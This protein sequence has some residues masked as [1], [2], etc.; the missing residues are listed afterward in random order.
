VVGGGRVAERKVATL[1]GADADVVVVAP[2]VTPSLRRR[3]SS[4]RIRWRRAAYRASHLRGA[5]F[6]V[7][8]TSNPSVNREVALAAGRAG[9]FVAVADDARLC[10]LFMPAVLRRGDLLVAVSTGGRSPGLARLLRDELARGLAPGHDALVR[11]VGALRESLRLGLR[12]ARE[13]ARLIGRILRAPV[14]SRAHS[15]S[16]R[17]GSAG[18]RRHGRSS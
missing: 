7:A 5:R 15:P 13:R 2:K 14:A 10:T 18:R 9:A 4:G 8:A 3:A 11:K 6:V 1:L 17:R 12:D 16:R